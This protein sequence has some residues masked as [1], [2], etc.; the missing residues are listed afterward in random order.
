M[1]DKESSKNFVKMMNENNLY[2]S[3]TDCNK[4]LN[5]IFNENANWGGD[6]KESP[7]K[8]NNIHIFDEVVKFLQKINIE[9]DFTLK[10]NTEKICDRKCLQLKEE[11][12][13]KKLKLDQINSELTNLFIENKLKCL[14]EVENC[15]NRPFG[16]YSNFS[17]LKH[18]KATYSFLTPD[19]WYNW[20]V[21]M[22][23]LN[24]P[25]ITIKFGQNSQFFK[26]ANEKSFNHAWE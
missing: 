7:K 12:V 17:E 18:E 15:K 11:F 6:S 2:F 1:F 9:D 13:E 16:R 25:Y 23:P 19:E 26:I 14:V 4:T 21:N 3:Q 8:V 20:E 24:N 22:I 5:L 10:I